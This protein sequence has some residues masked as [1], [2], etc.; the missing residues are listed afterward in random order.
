MRT[1]DERGATIAAQPVRGRS[2][3]SSAPELGFCVLAINSVDSLRAVHRLRHA[4]SLL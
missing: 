1:A 4:R 3:F 2:A